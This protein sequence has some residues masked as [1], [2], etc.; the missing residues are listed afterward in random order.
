MC[1]LEQEPAN[2]RSTPSTK[3]A[4]CSQGFDEG[5]MGGGG[6]LAAGVGLLDKL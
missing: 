4:V 2:S 1:A 6:T 5:T 3:K